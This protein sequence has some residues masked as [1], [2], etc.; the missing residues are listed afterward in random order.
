MR[1]AS[2][3]VGLLGGAAAFVLAF[4]V[5]FGLPYGKLDTLLAD[6]YH[7]GTPEPG[8]HFSMDLKSDSPACSGHMDASKW[9][10]AGDTFSADVCLEN[11]KL[12]VNLLGVGIFEFEVA[13][14]DTVIVAPNMP[15][16]GNGQDMNPDFDQVALSGNADPNTNG[17]DCSGFGV[18]YPTGD[19]DLSYAWGLRGAHIACYSL[20]GPYAFSTGSRR[21]ASIN[22]DVPLNAP[23]SGSVALD[24]VSMWVN[25]DEPSLTVATCDPTDPWYVDCYGAQVSLTT[26]CDA[27]RNGATNAMDAVAVLKAFGSRTNGPRWNPGADVNM[28]GRVNAVDLMAVLRAMRGQ[29]CSYVLPPA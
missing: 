7:D 28:D 12:G 14:D 18:V 6:P 1:R 26:R 17:W 23:S 15:I 10:A 27:N 3:L 13:Y 21:L 24:L 19:A 9:V 25:P 20:T 11:L 4:L 5:A 8:M 29:P 22:Y 2:I 16:V